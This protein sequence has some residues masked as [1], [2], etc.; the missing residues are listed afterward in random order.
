MDF[1]DGDSDL[2]KIVKKFGKY[3]E[4]Y[5][6]G[7]DDDVEVSHIICRTFLIFIL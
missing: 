4:D 3:V 6:K 2:L 5:M 7:F 1:T